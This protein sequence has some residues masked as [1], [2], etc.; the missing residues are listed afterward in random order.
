V[1]VES[2]GNS[3]AGLPPFTGRYSDGVKR[4]FA[5]AAVT[6]LALVLAAPT[7]AAAATAQRHDAYSLSF[8]SFD[9]DYTLTRDVD[10]FAVLTVVETIVAVFPDDD[11]NRGILRTIPQYYGH[12]PLRLSDFE[13]RDE[14][15]RSVYFEQSDIDTSYDGSNAYE[16]RAVELALGTD[17]F[18]HGPTTYVISYTAHDVVRAFQDSGDDELYWDVNGTEWA[19]SFGRVS[20]NL[21]VDGQLVSA[22]TGNTA[23]YWGSYGADSRCELGEPR[24]GEYTASVADVGAYE[25]VTVAI[26][27]DGGTF[28]QPQLAEDSWVITKAP[29]WLFLASLALLVA[30]CVVRFGLW[31]DSRGRGIIIPQY[32]TPDDR[33]LFEAGDLIERSGSA[34]AA[35]FVDLAVR[36]LVQVVD[37]YPDGAAAGISNR[38]ALDFVTKNGATKAELTIL[39]ILFTEL[40]EPGE[41]AILASLDSSVG[42]SLYEQTAKGR[43]SAIKHGL[44][45]QPPGSINVW[46]RRLGMLFVAGYIAV[47]IWTQVVAIDAGPL[48]GY[49]I[50]SIVVLLMASTLLAK[51]YVLSRSGAEAREYLLGM[52]DY[53]RLAEEERLRV[54]QS[55]E[56]AERVVTTDKRAIVALHEKLLPY[57]VLWGVEKEWARQL[58][59]EYQATAEDPS[60][61]GSS[62]S[63]VDLG[64]IMSTFSSTST[65]A[66]RPIVTTPSS[67]GGGGGGSSWS[68][69]GSSSFSSG[70]SGGGF[71]GGGGGGG[72]G[73]GR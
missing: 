63:T 19:Y 11:Q 30:A 61:I 66:V 22:L 16:Y 13:V 55:P 15:G 23:C 8:D 73:G 72:G 59:V 24:A 58:E 32:T 64:Q 65:S 12:V 27:F 28:T 17:E 41:R 46:L 1:A 54:L 7:S 45:V 56:G 21:H 9:A 31:R 25:N 68:S 34:M 62:L 3:F 29:L 37:L 70:S 20:V 4:F 38:F 33:D 60:W 14:N 52:R 51:P 67:G 6:L 35:Q 69:G 44:R 47:F 57:A 42:A 26:G 49:A 39:N 40:D 43:R 2:T 18:V 36:G 71:S 10:G 48:F 50:G 5:L 53:L